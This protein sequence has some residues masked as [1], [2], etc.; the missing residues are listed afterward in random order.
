MELDK[1][2]LLSKYS[3]NATKRTTERGELLKYFSEISGWDIKRVAGRLTKI[4]VPDLYYLK[5]KCEEARI[6]GAYFNW[7][8][9]PRKAVDNGVAEKK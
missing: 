4:E 9:N 2:A 7:A 3:S 1:D 6:P 8:T 5:K